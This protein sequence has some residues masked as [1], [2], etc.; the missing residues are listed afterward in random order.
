MRQV[1]AYYTTKI[2]LRKVIFEKRGWKIPIFRKIHYLFQKGERERER[3]RKRERDRQ[4]DRQ[5]HR[6]RD[7]Q[8]PRQI[9]RERERERERE[10]SYG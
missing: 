9:Q 8:R 7:R 5:R 10:T 2:Y 3:E 1:A 6:Q 4:T